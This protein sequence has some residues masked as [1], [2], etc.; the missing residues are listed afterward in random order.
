ME[1]ASENI[2]NKIYDYSISADIVNEDNDLMTNEFL[3]DITECHDITIIKKFFELIKKNSENILDY[4]ERTLQDEQGLPVGI[5]T[6]KNIK[7]VNT[8]TNKFLDK[9]DYFKKF[10][11]NCRKL[12]PIIEQ[13]RK[14]NVYTES[15]LENKITYMTENYTNI[16]PHG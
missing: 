11:W 14:K 3:V 13:E 6:I 2:Q 1:I 7:L 5:Y 8:K 10:Y 15:E 12:L 16:L 4:I 9:Y